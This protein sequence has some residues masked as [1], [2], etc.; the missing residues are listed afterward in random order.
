MLSLP[1]RDISEK[2]PKKTM[3]KA[4][5]IRNLTKTYRN[6][7]EALKG[8]DLDV[9]PGDF[10]ALLGPNGAGKS[11]TIGIIA[12]LVNKSGGKVSIFGHDL[13]REKDAAKACLGLVPQEFNFNT[14]EPVVE[15]VVNQ[16]GYYGIPRRQAFERAER[17]LRELGLWEKRR[18]MARNLSGGMKRRLMIARALVHEPQLLILDEPT[19]GVDIEIRRSMWAFL[20]EI[21]AEGRTIIL[22]T[23]YLEEAESLCR[24]I[25]IIDQGEIIENTSMKGLLGKLN[26]ETFV[27]DLARP[28]AHLPDL[29]GHTLRWVDELTLEA[30]IRK[31]DSVNQLFVD[32]AEADVPVLSLRNKTNRLEQLFMNLVRENRPS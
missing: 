25:A 7:F 14:F 9:E 28:M 30:D 27:L 24:N 12:S 5:S 1:A 3:P 11:T 15:I 29:P 22:T 32:L 31:Q 13:D 21:N 4:L 17:Y 2:T 8:I 19:A 10:F 23:H 16:A 6:G 20:R 18:D 26:V